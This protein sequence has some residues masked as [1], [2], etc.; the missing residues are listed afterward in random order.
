MRQNRQF[1]ADLVSFTEEM[2]NEK[3]HLLCSDSCKSI[4][5]SVPYTT[6]KSLLQE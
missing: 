1:P 4:S 2:L 6:H 3:L 5:R